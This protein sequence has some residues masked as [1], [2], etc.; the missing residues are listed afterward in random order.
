MEPGVRE[1]VAGSIDIAP[2]LLALAGLE[3]WK[4]GGR[5]LTRTDG[6]SDGA[7]GMLRTFHRVRPTERR[8]DGKE[9]VLTHPLFFIVDAAGQVHRGNAQ[10]S[11]GQPEADNEEI[12]ARFQ[13]FEQ[14]LPKRDEQKRLDPEV[15]EALRALGYVR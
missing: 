15:E 12:R 8:T 13:S 7:S 14:K 9:H 1:D 4:L 11:R 3:P 2:T 10:I 5:D 6:T